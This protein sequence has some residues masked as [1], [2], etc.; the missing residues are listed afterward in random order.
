MAR[1]R[2]R[3]S[4]R[5]DKG[6]GARQARS[7]STRSKPAA[8][9]EVVEEGG[10]MGIDDGIAIITTIVLLVAVLLVDYELG[11]NYGEGMFFK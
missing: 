6:A 2:S 3:T 4:S 11:T 5:S 7:K 9:V 10:G 8:E 1:S